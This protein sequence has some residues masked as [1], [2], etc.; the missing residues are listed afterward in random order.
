MSKFGLLSA[1][2]SDLLLTISELIVQISILASQFS[3]LLLDLVE[4]FCKSLALP[5]FSLKV[6]D[7]SILSFNNIVQ[8]INFPSNSFDFIFIVVDSSSDLGKLRYFSS[9]VFIL[10]FQSFV[11][12]VLFLESLNFA[13][14]L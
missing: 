6:S 9:L 1:R 5:N 12:F 10:L 14:Q 7:F 4:L 2:N 11:A 3:E 8:S 13:I